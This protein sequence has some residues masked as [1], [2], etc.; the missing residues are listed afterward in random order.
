MNIIGP[1]HGWELVCCR[2]CVGGKVV[3]LL[4]LG[5]MDTFVLSLLSLFIL[6]IMINDFLLW[7]G[8]FHLRLSKLQEMWDT[9]ETKRLVFFFFDNKKWK[10]H[11]ALKTESEIGLKERKSVNREPGEWLWLT[12][13]YCSFI[14]HEIKKINT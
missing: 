8:H 1:E 11:P 10:P 13:N 9:K 12:Y 3:E 4:G 5:N 2:M 6:L 14:A 7:K